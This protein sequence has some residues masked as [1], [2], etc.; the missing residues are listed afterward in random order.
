VSKLGNVSLGNIL[1]VEPKTS[2]PYTTRQPIGEASSIA[3]HNSSQ[4]R[5]W[6]ISG[7]LHNPSQAEVEQLKALQNGE[8]LL[9]DVPSYYFVAFGKLLSCG[10]HNS[11]AKQKALYYDLLFQSVPAVGYVSSQTSGVFLHDLSYR[12]KLSALDPHLT[13]CLLTYDANRLKLDY[14][15]YVCN[16]D[17]DAVTA[18]LEFGVGADHSKFT[19]YAWNGTTYVLVGSWGAGATAW[20]TGVAYND[21]VTAHTVTAE[22]GVRGE[23][24]TNGTVSYRLGCKNKV[25]LSITALQGNGGGSTDFAGGQLR[26]KVVL[27]HSAAESGVRDYIRVVYADGSVGGE[28][29]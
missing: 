8:V 4:T 12:T 18:L 19:V 3:Q 23:S 11:A 24:L 26:L 1:S 22:K 6:L 9:L 29:T 14:Q 28:V 25:L 17:A 10:F 21:G 5:Q 16:R 20:G 7:C 2:L 15:F 13:H 27:E